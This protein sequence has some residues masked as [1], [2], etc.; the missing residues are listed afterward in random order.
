MEKIIVEGE[1]QTVGD[2]TNVLVVTHTSSN[3]HYSSLNVSVNVVGVL[4]DEEVINIWRKQM[5]PADELEAARLF[6]KKK[7]NYAVSQCTDKQNDIAYGSIVKY[8]TKK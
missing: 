6:L 7:A 5:T 1:V 2:G 4:S 3:R 8:K